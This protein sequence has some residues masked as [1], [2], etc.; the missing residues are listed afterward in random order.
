M[1][2]R[3]RTG[4]STAIQYE[5]FQ[6]K[7]ELKEEGGANILVVHLPGFQKEQINISYVHSS[8]LIRVIGE[9]LIVGNKWSRFNQAFS[10]PQNCDVQKIQA[11]FQNGVLTITMP[12]LQPSIPDN[13]TS[14]SVAVE[15]GKE[16]T[17][18]PQ[19]PQQAKTYVATQKQSDGKQVEGAPSPG[20]ALKDPKSQTQVEATSNVASITDDTMKTKDKKGAKVGEEKTIEKKEKGELYDKASESNQE[21]TSKR[22]KESLLA[23]QSEE[24]TKKRKEVMVTRPDER[25][26]SGKFG[27]GEEKPKEDFF[28]DKVK[29]VAAAAKKNV[30]ELSEERQLL[31]NIGVAVLV[32]VALGAYIS[33]SYRSSG[34]SMD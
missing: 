32:I 27:G 4:G 2:T 14:T 25:T 28:T 9:R 18:A 21:E 15:E 11:K 16:K 31:V 34:K 20:E 3:T 30:M 5:D 22:I 6:P 1:A 10:V 12:K 26:R 8:R 13:L 29:N 33:Y 24:R 19:I 17:V 7:S 23:D